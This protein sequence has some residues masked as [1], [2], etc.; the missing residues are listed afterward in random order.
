M[1][2]VTPITDVAGAQFNANGTHALVGLAAIEEHEG[3]YKD[4][5]ELLHTAAT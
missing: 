5:V 4:A 3:N 2:S 1:S